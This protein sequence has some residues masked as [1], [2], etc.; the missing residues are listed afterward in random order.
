MPD[1]FDLNVERSAPTLQQDG[2]DYII[3]QAPDGFVIDPLTDWILGAVAHIQASIATLAGQIA[4]SVF[5][6]FVTQILGI[7]PV[8]A[9][10]ASGSA[11][12][13]LT[14]NSAD[15]TILA[16]AALDVNGVPFLTTQDAVFVHSGS[17][18]A[19]VTIGAFDGGVSGNNLSGP[20]TMT[21]PS[22]T[23]V[24]HI[25][26]AASTSGGVDAEDG[27][28][29]IN[30]AADELPTLS[31]K[32]IYLSDL[33]QIARSDVEVLRALPIKGLLGASTNVVGAASVVL[34]SIAGG[35]TLVSAPGKARV[36]ANLVDEDNLIVNVQVAVLDPTFNDIDVGYTATVYSGQDTT[37]LQGII[38]AAIVNYFDS[39]KWGVPNTDRT[40]LEWVEEKTV[41]INDLYR[42]IGDVVGV[43]H[44]GSVQLALHG[45]VLGS[46]NLTLTGPGALPGN[47]VIVAHTV[48]VG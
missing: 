43:H 2:R 19:T 14:D 10:Q 28:T 40:N 3:A 24:D 15:L 48:T 42:I 5:E 17:T 25:T 30:R 7:Q 35:E 39:T 32:S 12:I 38:D 33:A 44:V 36:L 6:I 8:D 46:A 9:V 23:R 21:A 29:F 16:G 26:V 45:N 22:L 47:I 37:S 4:P 27:L 20:A 11:T 1:Y 34:Q 18:S 41:Y 31:P 13:V